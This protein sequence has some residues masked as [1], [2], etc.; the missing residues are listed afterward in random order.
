[1][2]TFN[3]LNLGAGV[4]SSRIFLA[5]CRGELLKFDAAVF[6]DTQWEPKGVYGTLAFLKAEGAKAGVPVVQD[7]KGDLRADAVEFRNDLD[8]RRT[9]S[10]SLRSPLFIKNKNGIT[11]ASEAA[12]HARVQDRGR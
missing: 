4:Q 7:T 12:M 5:S 9:V 2:R 8:D 1:M 3:V 11:R 10:V 6:A